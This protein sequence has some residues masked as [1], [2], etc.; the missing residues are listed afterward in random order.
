MKSAKKGQKRS[1][2]S[3]APTGILSLQAHQRTRK[4]AP[5]RKS[6]M[7]T[8]QRAVSADEKVLWDRLATEIGCVACMLDH[9]RNTYVSIHHT[10][11]RTKPGCHKLVLPLCAPHHQQDDTDPLQRIAVHPNKARFEAR[12]GSQAELM[13]ICEQILNEVR[14]AAAPVATPNQFSEQP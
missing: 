5:A 11:G 8:K 4:A 10:D 9:R 6:T 12:Y 3:Q 13:A 7:K 2:F 1:G 14:P